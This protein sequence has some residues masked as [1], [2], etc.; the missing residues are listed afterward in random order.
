MRLR[1][2]EGLVSINSERV[3]IFDKVVGVHDRYGLHAYFAALDNADLR[4]TLDA[5]LQ[6]TLQLS[7]ERKIHLR[8]VLRGGIQPRP[9]VAEPE[10]VSAKRGTS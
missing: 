9:Q 3:S 7:E 2:A 6:D 8:E 5:E 10:S 1:A 4:A